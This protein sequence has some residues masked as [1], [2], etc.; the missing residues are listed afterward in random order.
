MRG[1]SATQFFKQLTE[2]AE[3]TL[4]ASIEIVCRNLEYDRPPMAVLALGK[5]GTGH[6]S[7]ESDLDLVFVFDDGFDLERASKIVRRIQTALMVKLQ[8]GIAYELDMRLRPSG[9]S[10]PAAVSFESFTRYHDEKAKTWEHIALCS[11]RCVAGDTAMQ[12]KVDAAVAQIIARPRDAEQCRHDAGLMWSRINEQRVE[13]GQSGMFADKMAEGGLM[14]AEYAQTSQQL[15][16]GSGEGLEAAV[17]FWRVL[18]LWQRLLD[19]KGQAF[20]DITGQYKD[21]ILT[22]VGAKSLE[23]MTE[24]ATQHKDKVIDATE[25]L[26]GDLAIDKVAVELPIKWS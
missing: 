6:M 4:E 20:H 12:K 7:P 19:L 13:A 8:E 22:S 26:F 3:I 1:G 5:M 11:A 24:L 23:D 25:R 2:L 10:G 17:D 16:G 18:Q 21:A 15:M 14:Q 9:R